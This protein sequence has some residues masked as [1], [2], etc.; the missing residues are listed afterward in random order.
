M[1]RKICLILSF[2]LIFCMLT[3]C[4]TDKDDDDKETTTEKE[5]TKE[6]SGNSSSNGSYLSDD[7][8][9]SGTHHV[10]IDVE[11]YG[12]IKAELY[13]DIAPI[14]VSNFVALAKSGFYD[15]LT[16]HRIMSG[17]MIQGGDP[18]G[19]GY[20][21]SE[22]TIPGEFK[23]NGFENNL[24][25]T[26]G[27]LSMARNSVDMNSASSQFFIMHVDYTGLDGDYAAF[28]KVTEGMEVVDAICND[29]QPIDNN[30]TIPADKQPKINSIKV[31]D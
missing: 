4:G 15:G 12:V 23:A 6:V 28:G 8:I 31:I 1:K 24:S 3:A 9:L 22:N 19:T 21:G 7:Q 27:V 14:T 17:F 5:T 26:R 2:C 25:H 29:S 11:G 30:G 20:G 18:E 13:A 16:F 10:E